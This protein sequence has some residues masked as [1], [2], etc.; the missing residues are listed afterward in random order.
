MAHWVGQ[1]VQNPISE[2]NEHVLAKNKNLEE[3]W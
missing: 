3:S 2:W 1:I